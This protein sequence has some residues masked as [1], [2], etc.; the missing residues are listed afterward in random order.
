MDYYRIQVGLTNGKILT[1][2]EFKFL[3]NI[4]A[5]VTQYSGGL[6]IKN[7]GKLKMAYGNLYGTHFGNWFQ[8]TT[9]N[10]DGMIMFLN[11]NQNNESQNKAVGYEILN[12]VKANTFTER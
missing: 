12:H 7:D 8:M 2:D 3:T 5:K 11:Q 1:E 9:D 10:K 4:Q 6:Y